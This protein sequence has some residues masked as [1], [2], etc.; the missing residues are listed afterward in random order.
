MMVE[1]LPSDMTEMFTRKSS[2]SSFEPP[3]IARTIRMEVFHTKFELKVRLTGLFMSYLR[4]LL[5]LSCGTAQISNVLT[6][7]SVKKQG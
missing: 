1:L 6:H 2:C 4:D 5:L 7:L 3:F